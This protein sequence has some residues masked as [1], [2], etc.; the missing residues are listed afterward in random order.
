M[1]RRGGLAVSTPTPSPVA[2]VSLNTALDRTVLVDTLT[3][4]TTHV[5]QA[6]LVGAGG[7]AFNVARV[8]R[9]LGLDVHVVGFAGGRTGETVRALADREGLSATWV[10]TAGET[11]TCTVLVDA[12]GQATVINGQGPTVRPA[13]YETLRRVV[14]RHV[15]Q[16]NMVVLTGSTPPG[17]PV[18]AYAD[19]VRQGRASGA[20]TVVDASGE[21]LRA[22]AEAS[23]TVLK[24]NRDEF[25]QLC[26]QDFARCARHLVESGTKLV[27]ITLGAEGSV[28]FAPDASWRVPNVPTQVVNP[29]AAGDAFLGALLGA[30]K[31][32]RPLERCLAYATAAAV[33]NTRQLAPGTSDPLSVARLAQTIIPIPLP[34]NWEWT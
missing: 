10:Q 8:A 4:G 20:V 29:T 19:I 13:E 21:R 6:D 5:A 3:P 2:V 7:K 24:V 25:A 1:L 18:G 26:E 23:P 22:A 28:A 34:S 11:R 17:A 16:G 12:A 33:L 15:A 30:L 32:S 31:D 14:D 9:I 27:V